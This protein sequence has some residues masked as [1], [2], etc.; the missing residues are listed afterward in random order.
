[1]ASPAQQRDA[2]AGLA[3]SAVAAVQVEVAKGAEEAR[4]PSGVCASKGE[5]QVDSHWRS[6]VRMGARIA[7]ETGT[8][9]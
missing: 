8:G 1:M 4:I 9:A 6:Y 5:V 7:P 3:D 2:R